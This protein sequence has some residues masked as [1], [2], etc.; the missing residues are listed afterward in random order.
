MRV[1]EL[2]AA[3]E[4]IAPSHFAEPWDNVGLLA[5]DPRTSLR[6]PVLLCLDLTDA[7][8]DEVVSRRAGAVVVYHPPIFEPIRRLTPQAPHGGALLR[9]IGAGSVVLS[10]HTALDAA[11]GGL[12]DWLGDQVAEGPGS[13]GEAGRRAIAAATVSDPNQ[14]HKIV[15]FVP[16]EPAEA[17]AKVREAMAGAGAGNIGAYSQCSFGLRGEGTFLG[18]EGANPTVGQRGRLERVEE[19]RLEMV[20]SATA[21]A[22]VVDA[23]RRAHPYE[24]PA[25]DVYALAPRPHPAAGAGRLLTL[26]SPVT[27]D[28]IAGRLRTR[29]KTGVSVGAPPAVAAT[30]RVAVVPGSGASLLASACALGAG[31]FVTGEMKHHDLLA[32]NENNCAV[33]LLG[34]GESERPYL[35]ILAQR[36]AKACPGI[37]IEVAKADRPMLRSV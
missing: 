35:P 16:A 11:P 4:S 15:V 24:E 12:A 36:L 27:P 28:E 5:G 19:V 17:L 1:A 22:S 14:S 30:K 32:A 7:V 20:C 37:V 3:L 2:S 13:S 31:V 10:P 8:A 23:L 33:V 6:G 18:G 26:R 34:H 29:L 9:V 21:L 25:F